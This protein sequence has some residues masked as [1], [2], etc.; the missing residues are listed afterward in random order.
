[1]SELQSGKTST[2]E[3]PDAPTSQPV[4][5]PGFRRM[6]YD[7]G[8]EIA[9]ARH[10]LIFDRA[11]ARVVRYEVISYNPHRGWQAV[12]RVN[13]ANVD[14]VWLVDDNPDFWSEAELAAGRAPLGPITGDG[15][16]AIM[17]IDLHDPTPFLNVSMYPLE[18][19]DALEDARTIVDAERASSPDL[20]AQMERRYGPGKWVTV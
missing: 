9:A 17:P 6:T 11:L 10:V 13:G 15:C 2:V 4:L 14:T 8:R 5:P 18:A 12:I 20:L 16:I 7:E 1:M 19:N 3:A